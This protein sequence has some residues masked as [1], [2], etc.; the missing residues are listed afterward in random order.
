MVRMK[1]LAGDFLDGTGEYEDGVMS[2][3]SSLYPWPG[4]KIDISKIRSIEVVS[5]EANK[6]IGSSV[7]Q[8]VAGGLVMGPLGAIAGFML[9]DEFKEV[10]FMATLKDGRK[11][12][13][14]IDEKAFSQ[15]SDAHVP[16]KTFMH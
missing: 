4:I 12:L 3:E 11:I 6:A 5:K 14:T 16:S 13:A 8:G 2:I 1:I 10:T 7:L 15:L 9:G